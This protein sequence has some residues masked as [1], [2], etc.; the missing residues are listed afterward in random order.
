MANWNSYKS[1][2]F[3]IAACKKRSTCTTPSIEEA[4]E[5]SE[6]GDDKLFS[7]ITSYFNYWNENH[8]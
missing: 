1:I 2:L 6:E 5:S 8:T 7:N 4:T 3:W